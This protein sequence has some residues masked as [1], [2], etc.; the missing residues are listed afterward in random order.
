M[1]FYV[2]QVCLD[3]NVISQNNNQYDLL[4]C[5]QV[6]PI[7][8]PFRLQESSTARQNSMLLTKYVSINLFHFTNFILYFQHNNNNKGV[9]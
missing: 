2:K 7:Y 9:P 4:D 6:I 5:L 8:F 1:Q 3:F